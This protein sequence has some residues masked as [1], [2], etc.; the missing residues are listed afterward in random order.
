MSE[1][2]TELE[3]AVKLAPQEPLARLQLA[4]V[5]ERA[6]DWTGVVEQYRALREMKPEEP[7]YVYGLGN[8]YLHLS[9]WCLRELD[10]LDGGLGPPPAGAGPQ[11]PRAGATGSRPRP[12]SSVRRG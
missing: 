7:E 4:R 2:R 5:E 3:R 1:A 9:E 10:T 6:G 11:L 8:A 12:P